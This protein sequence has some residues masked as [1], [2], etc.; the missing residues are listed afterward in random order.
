MALGRQRVSA[1]SSPCWGLWPFPLLRHNLQ[2]LHLHQ[3]ISQFPFS[4]QGPT[5]VS[6]QSSPEPVRAGLGLRACPG[7]GVLRVKIK[8]VHHDP[9]PSCETLG[10]AG[11][12]LWILQER[13]G[14]SKGAA[15]LFSS[16]LEL[17]GWLQRCPGSPRGAQLCHTFLGRASKEQTQPKEPSW[18]PRGP[19]PLFPQ[20]LPVIPFS[21]GSRQESAA[22]PGRW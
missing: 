3:V 10:A 21:A 4:H 7:F 6:C 17:L 11:T 13:N 16:S 15:G 22:V 9:N 1:R 12:Q 18:A 2:E 8:S 20:G 19:S 5:S 14:D